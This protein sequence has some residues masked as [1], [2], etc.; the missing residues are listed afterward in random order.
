MSAGEE[1]ARADI[2]QFQVGQFLNKFFGAQAVG[3]EIKHI[4]DANAHTALQAR[5]PH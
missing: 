5:P 2:G 1:Q 4:T 3:Q